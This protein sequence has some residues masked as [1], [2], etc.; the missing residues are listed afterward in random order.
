VANVNTMS[1]MFASATSF[2][3]DIGGWNV[4]NVE[5]MSTM[6][7][8][9]TSFNQNIGSWNMANANSLGYMFLGATS[10]NQN[11]CGWTRLSRSCTDLFK[12]SGC[13]EKSNIDIC[14]T[15]GT[16]VAACQTCGSPGSPQSIT[17]TFS[18]NFSGF[19]AVFDVIPLTN[20][21]ITDMKVNLSGGSTVTIRLYTKVGTHVGF[22]ET[23]S[24]WTL[25][26]TAMVTAAGSGQQTDFPLSSSIFL[27][28]NERRAFYF[29]KI[30]GSGSFGLTHMGSGGYS[31]GD[32]YTSNSDIEI[33]V[34]SSNANLFGAINGAPYAW[35]GV[36][37]YT[38]YG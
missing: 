31:I 2:N 35:N 7:N 25:V 9:A 11:L 21:E 15:S 5:N 29:H 10:F 4:A 14:S 30:S 24:A 37:E 17:T 36:L 33:Y 3:Q 6:F 38:P 12:D 32:L 8:G 1:W 16:L 18:S 23:S 34:G 26:K 27:T 13:P 20:M 22:E 28:K 19:G